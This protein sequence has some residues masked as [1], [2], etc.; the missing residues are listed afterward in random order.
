MSRASIGRNYAETL[1]ELGSREG[2]IEA[3]GEWL[4]EVAALHREE[5][6]FRRLVE[7][8]RISLT[9]KRSA[10]R[11]VFS[12][13][14]PL[15]FLRFLLVALEK[16]RL[17]LLPEIEE[18]YRELL[19]ERAGR[20]RAVVTLAREPDAE[21]RKEIRAALER[22]LGREVIPTFRRDEAILG[23]VVVRVEDRLMDGS[24]R[25]RLHDLRRVLIEEGD[26][27]PQAG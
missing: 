21:L 25:R 26:H 8:P 22:F 24:L 11:E 2:A 18:A 10:L 15:L 19:D 27:T 17:S 4:G 1:L 14:Y 23:G 7:T 9:E 16:G 3:Y 20:V 13:R 12:D 6:D 5:P